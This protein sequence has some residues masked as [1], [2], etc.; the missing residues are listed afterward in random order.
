M[1]ATCNKII[2][3]FVFLFLQ[4]PWKRAKMRFR[5]KIY[6]HVNIITSKFFKGEHCGKDLC[7]ALNNEVTYYCI[8]PYNGLPK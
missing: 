5:V 6:V 4:C 3:Y 7:L 1:D 2:I 8:W